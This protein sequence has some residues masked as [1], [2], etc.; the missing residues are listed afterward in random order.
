M[1]A[2]CQG[3]EANLES[4]GSSRKSLSDKVECQEGRKE[5]RK[6]WREGRRK[7]ERKK[8]KREGEESGKEGRKDLS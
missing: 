7:V 1:V 6:G 3:F 8:E 5:G 2:H 4:I